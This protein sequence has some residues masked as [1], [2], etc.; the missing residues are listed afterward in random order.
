MGLTLTRRLTASH[1]GHVW[2]ESEGEGKG[3]RFIVVLPLIPVLDNKVRPE[4]RKNLYCSDDEMRGDLLQC[5]LEKTI[6]SSKKNGS[7]FNLCRLDGNGGVAEEKRY[8]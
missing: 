1:G 5:N 3:S 4:S 2:A 8:R 6:S 7:T